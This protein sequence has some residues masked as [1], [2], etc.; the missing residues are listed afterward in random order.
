MACDCEVFECIKVYVSPCDTGVST[1][2]VVPDSGDYLVRL[3]FN[4]AYQE[5]TLSMEA[6]G[7][8][9]LPNIVNGNYIHELLIYNPEGNL[10]ND[11]CYR[12][13]VSTIFTAGNGLTPSPST[14]GFDRV[15]ILTSDMVSVDGSTITNSFFGGKVINEI[16]TDNQAY[17]V[18]VA[19]SQ[20]GNVITGINISFYI[21]Q[22]IKISW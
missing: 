11:T 7:I 18:G 20:N 2:I 4:S 3:K 16:D 13:D 1:S 22:V 14:S 6:D 12:L 8:I 5:I 19:F 9:I 10:F 17:L 15:I 21:G